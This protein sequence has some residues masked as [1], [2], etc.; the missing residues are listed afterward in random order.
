LFLR[1]VRAIADGNL[2]QLQTTAKTSL[3]AAI[4]EANSKAV[5]AKHLAGSLYYVASTLAD[6]DAITGMGDLWTCAMNETGTTYYYDAVDGPQWK[7]LPAAWAKL[8][9]FVR[10]TT[11]RDNIP[12]PAQ[13]MTCGVL[14]DA[15]V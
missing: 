5:S 11:D 8:N 13:G 3:V 1:L 4:N 7:A 14:A 2:S 6:R 12:G 15:S 9:K 10:T